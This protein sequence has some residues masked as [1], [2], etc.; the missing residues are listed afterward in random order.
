MYL[1]NKQQGEVDAFTVK[2]IEDAYKLLQDHPECKSLL[3][4]H[5]TKDV[6]DQLKYK[7]TRLG[8]TL[9]DV[10]RS[11]VFNLDAGVGVYAPDA[12]SYKT[13]S[14]LFDPIIQEYH[15]F[16][17]NDKQP[18][19][20]LGEGRTSDFPPLDPQGK[21]IKSTRIRCGRTLAGYPFNPLLTS[22]DYLIMQQKVRNALADVKDSD[23]KGVYYPLDGMKKEV[24]NQLIA[25]HFLF[26]EGDRHLQGAN[27]C[28]YWPKGR[29]IFHNNEKTFLIWV[30]EEDHLRIISMEEGSDV[31]KILDRLIRGVKSIEKIVPFARDSRLGY[32]TFCPTNLG[33]TVRA[34]VHIKLPQLSTQKDF[35]KICDDLNLQVRGSD[36]EHSQ[37]KGGIMDIS[38]KQRLGLTE[39]QAVKQ[40]YDGI[41]KLI[42]LEEAATV[43]K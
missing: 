32:L 43:G 28:N 7:K 12:E 6:L 27:A 2:K 13:F 20:D 29:G 33:T 26:K 24:Q 23:L 36:G 30:N 1:V 8:A 9:Y 15:G 41:K 3:K 40:M 39:Y 38:N 10:I 34:S 11:G 18:A 17:P 19:V 35:K 42:E 22:D 31:G 16:G 14:P 25:D 21:Y 5:F 4:K 37:S